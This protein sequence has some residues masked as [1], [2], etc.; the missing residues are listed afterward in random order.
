MTAEIIEL[1]DD[2]FDEEVL[3]SPSP[4]I[5][6]FTASWSEPC[7]TITPVVRELAQVWAGKITV[8]SLDVDEHYRTAHRHGILS[9]PM[10]LLYKKGR[11]IER[12]IGLIP[13]KDIERRVRNALLD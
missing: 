10:L 13:R 12:I 9:I 1:A 3:Q 6:F 4:V 11:A 7:K 2:R 5:V 8:T